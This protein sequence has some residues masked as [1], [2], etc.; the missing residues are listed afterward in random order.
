MKD[1]LTAE[2][3]INA[4]TEE[5]DHLWVKISVTVLKVW[6]DHESIAT[7]IDAEAQRQADE[8]AVYGCYFCDVMLTLETLGTKCPGPTT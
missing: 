8:D 6:R 4:K 5:Q 7:A 3:I 2:D 1:I